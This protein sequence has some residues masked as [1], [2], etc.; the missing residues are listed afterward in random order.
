MLSFVVLLGN[1]KLLQSRF[2][3]RMR[4]VKL[5]SSV[6]CACRKPHSGPPQKHIWFCLKDT[7]SLATVLCTGD[8]GH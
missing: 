2:E 6:L 7:E 8:I 5:V 3:L 4:D 1:L